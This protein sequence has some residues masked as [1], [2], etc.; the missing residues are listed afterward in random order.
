MPRWD[1][2]CDWCEFKTELPVREFICPAC[3]V[4]SGAERLMTRLPSAPNFA[5]K[6][7]GWTP[8]FHG[9]KA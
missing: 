8:R 6:G 5:L 2:E 7:S 3:Y 1:F 4:E 9:G